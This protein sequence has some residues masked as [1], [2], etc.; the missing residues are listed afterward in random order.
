MCSI[1][2]GRSRIAA[3]DAPT[4]PP[5]DMLP[6]CLARASRGTVTC[7]PRRLG[8]PRPL[9]ERLGL[10]CDRNQCVVL[11]SPMPI[12]R[13]S[14]RMRNSREGGGRERGPCPNRR[15]ISCDELLPAEAFDVAR[16][17]EAPMAGLPFVK[18]ESLAANGWVVLSEIEVYP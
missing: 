5:D 13:P 14:H 6:G 3:R 8:R 18:G 4:A 10:S 9:A 11:D 12:P 2:P 15:K 1:T 17:A 16:M 7:L